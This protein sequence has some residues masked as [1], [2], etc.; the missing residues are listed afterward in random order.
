MKDS[1]AVGLD[2]NANHIRSATSG[3]V[4]GITKPIHIGG[5]TQV[6][7]IKIYDENESLICVSRIT[8][9]VLQRKEAFTSKMESFD[10]KKKEA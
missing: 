5:K 6:W 10:V 3:R 9:A 4:K 8:L 7:E 1:Y 2:I